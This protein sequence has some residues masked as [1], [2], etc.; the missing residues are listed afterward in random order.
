M[1]EEG[2]EVQIS[3]GVWPVGP[4]QCRSY[5]RPGDRVKVQC[6]TSDH[7]FVYVSYQR[8]CGYVPVS[9]VVEVK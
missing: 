5:V 6:T 1:F 3:G 4:E 7:K 2:S 9:C 8:S